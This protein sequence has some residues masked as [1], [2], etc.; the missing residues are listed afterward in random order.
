MAGLAELCTKKNYIASNYCSDTYRTEVEIDGQ[1]SVMDIVHIS[2]PFSKEKE[3]ALKIRYGLSDTDLLKYYKTFSNNLKHGWQAE[4]FLRKAGNENADLASLYRKKV[5]VLKEEGQRGSDIFIV[6]EPS[7]AITSGSIMSRDGITFHHLLNLGIRLLQTVKTYSK[8]GFS[9]GFFDIDSMCAVADG[10]GRQ[11]I[12]T[13]YFGMSQFEDSSP[14]FTPEAETYLP[15]EVLDGTKEL[16][17]DS[18]LYSVCSLLLAML[19]GRHYSSE[20]D[21]DRIPVYSRPELTQA[22]EAVME[23]G[24]EA[25]KNLDLTLRACMKKYPDSYIRFSAPCEGYPDYEPEEHIGDVLAQKRALSDDDF[26]YDDFE[27]GDG[28]RPERKGMKAAYAVLFAGAALYVILAVL[29][30]LGIDPSL[31]KGL[32]ETG[33]SS[34]DGFYLYGDEVVNADGIPCA[35]FV[36]DSDGNVYTVPE[37]N[38]NGEEGEL[39]YRADFVDPFIPVSEIRLEVLSSEYITLP[40]P[41]NYGYREDVILIE[42]GGADYDGTAGIIGIEEDVVERSGISGGSIVVLN[43]GDAAEAYILGEMTGRDRD[44]EGRE[45]IYFKIEGNPP[46]IYVYN[47]GAEQIEEAMANEALRELTGEDWLGGTGIF[48]IKAEI[49]PEDRTPESIVFETDDPVAIYDAGGAEIRNGE[50]VSTGGENV[51]IFEVRSN[52]KGIF[53]VRISDRGGLYVKE[54]KLEFAEGNREINPEPA[55]L[56]EPA[57]TPAATPEP[58]PEPSPTPSPAPSQAPVQTGETT[59]T[60]YTPSSGSASSPEPSTEPESTEFAV[61]AESVEVVAGETFRIATSGYDGGSLY[62]FSSDGEIAT[63]VINGNVDGEYTVTGIAPGTCF[64]TFRAATG[65]EIKVTVTVT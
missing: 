5:T 28:N 49:L 61:S 46:D 45:R 13:G 37:E 57:A 26:N 42:T 7:E 1:T 24:E 3:E 50:T 41:E 64:I 56:P 58:A 22:I 6:R 63:A 8:C 10:T 27:E 36:L 29:P 62:V 52:T 2:L 53:S 38:E 35:G 47:A 19:D 31:R 33:R 23:N 51:F 55:E 32:P 39:A 15:D 14:T 60:G 17:F 25:L 16:S 18:D 12:K 9:I 34:E 20:P 48:R 54:M 21:R 44:D 59:V 4:D 30:K 65:K 40:T 43:G 11:I